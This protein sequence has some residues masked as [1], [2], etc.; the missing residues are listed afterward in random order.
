MHPRTRSL[1]ALPRS[2]N[3]IHTCSPPPFAA[4][5]ARSRPWTPAS[6]HSLNPIHTRSP[7]PFAAAPARGRPWTPASLRSLNPIHTRSPPPFAAASARGRPWTPNFGCA[8]TLNCLAAFADPSTPALHPHS[9]PSPCPNLPPPRSLSPLHTPS[10]LLHPLDAA[11]EH[12]N[13][14]TLKTDPPPR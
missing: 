12:P 1:A 6:P 7:P 2:L 8:R 4:A 9:L 5:P 3:P 14:C 10:A 11:P 13:P